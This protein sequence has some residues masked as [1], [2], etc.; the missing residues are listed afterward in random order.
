MSSIK[1]P[2]QTSPDSLT[3]I[4]QNGGRWLATIHDPKQRDEV[5]CAINEHDDLKARCEKAVGALR[6]VWDGLNETDHDWAFD[7]ITT[8]LEELG[9]INV[10]QDQGPERSG[11]DAIEGSE[12]NPQL[13]RQGET[14]QTDH[15]VGEEDSGDI[16]SGSG[17]CEVGGV[18]SYPNCEDSVAD[19]GS[20]FCPFHEKMMYKGDGDV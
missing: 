14:G 4:D 7:I 15:S 20:A 9:E 8:A 10:R 18:C 13:G 17:A 12:P 11:S 19:T 6:E 1:K 3:W 5:I 16:T 2:V